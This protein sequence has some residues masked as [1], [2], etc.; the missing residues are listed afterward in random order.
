MNLRKKF[1][2]VVL[3]VALALFSTATVYAAT[4]IGN[5]VSVGGTLSVAGVSTL[6][7]NLLP[8]TDN[9][10][11]IGA[12]STQ[13]Q[14]GNFQAGVLVGNGSN[15]STLAK[16]SLIVGE[17]ANY[18]MGKFYVD[19]SGNVSA[20]GTLGVTGAVT[21]SDALAVTGNTTLTG[22]L[23]AAA[24][25]S[26]NIGAYGTAFANVY[27]SST[28]YSASST[29]YNPSTTSTV[30]VSSGAS[31]TGGQLILKAHNGTC[32]AVYIGVF[33]NGVLGVTS[34]ALSSCY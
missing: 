18:N 34:T 23:Y 28:V 11:N 6:S 2:Y 26:K 22:H 27:A 1:F 14:Y 25:N 5:N 17:A 3:F 21:L 29:V 19:S 30:Y 20:S 7:G 4:T 10:Y 8:G 32:Y 15:T 33:N 12:S 9:L 13:W 16:A 31:N 24:N